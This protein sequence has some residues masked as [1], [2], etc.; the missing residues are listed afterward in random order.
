MRKKSVHASQSLL[1]TGKTSSFCNMFC[2]MKVPSCVTV[3][4]QLHTTGS[5]LM[6][7]RRQEAEGHRQKGKTLEVARVLVHSQQ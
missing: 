2:A 3:A 1:K 7:Q 4:I 5:W 6:C